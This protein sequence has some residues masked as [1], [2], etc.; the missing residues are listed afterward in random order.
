V[1]YLLPNCFTHFLTF[2]DHISVVYHSISSLVCIVVSSGIFWSFQTHVVIQS[3]HTWN[4]VD[5]ST[6][7]KIVDSKWIFKIKHLFDGSVDK[8]QAR[9]VRKVY[10]QIQG[11]DYDDMFAPVVP[12]DSLRLLLSI[13]TANGFISQ[14]LDVK[15]AFLYGELHEII[16]IHLPKGYRDRK[17]VA[18]PKRCIYGLK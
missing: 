13:V 1:I 6:D 12:F 2:G 9:L 15:A 5:R 14:Q 17:K 3:N 4:V 18:H 7:R 8:F 11:Q 16:Y 10:F